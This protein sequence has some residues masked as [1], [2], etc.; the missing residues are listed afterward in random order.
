LFIFNE[1]MQTCNPLQNIFLLHQMLR[2]QH[3][4][5]LPWKSQVVHE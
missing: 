5:L 4:L 3:L 1:G 2:L